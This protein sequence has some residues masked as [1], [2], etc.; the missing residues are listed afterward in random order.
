[1]LHDATPM[2]CESASNSELLRLQPL[3]DPPSCFKQEINGLLNR[4]IH[5]YNNDKS[6]A[7]SAGQQQGVVTAISQPNGKAY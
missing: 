7:F 2:C 6:E 5:Q 3:R 4:H 1:M